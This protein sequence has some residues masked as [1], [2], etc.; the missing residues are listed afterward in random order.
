MIWIQAILAAGHLAAAGLAAVGPLLVAGQRAMPR[1]RGDD[2]LDERLRAVAV[3]CCWAVV[4]AA[5][6]GLAAGAVRWGSDTAYEQMLG[7]FPAHAYA[8]VAGEWLFTL[9]C[10]FAWVGLWRRWRHR[11]WLPA[12]LVLVGATNLLY[13]FPPLMI[14]QNLLAENPSL[15]ATTVV[16]RSA[17]VGVMQQPV[18]V[19]KTLHIAGMGLVVSA[20]AVLMAVAGSGSQA[21]LL[22]T[23]WSASAALLAFAWQWI[24]GVAIIALL[25]TAAGAPMIGGS[26]AAAGAMVLGLLLTVHLMF[27]L[28]QLALAPGTAYR[29]VGLGI[30]LGGVLLLMSLAARLGG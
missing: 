2:T 26:V 14:G 9:A 23:R 29:P 8:M 7:R 17:M 12:G 25:P 22:A 3:G 15:V 19:A 28:A 24:S 20:V 10:Y 6:T 30:M 1:T 11:I 5:A 4:A 27:V 16:E 18:V 21:G 13:H